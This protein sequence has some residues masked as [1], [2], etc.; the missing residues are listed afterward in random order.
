MA[1]D[2]IAAWDEI[3]SANLLKCGNN[4]AEAI[5]RSVKENRDAHSAYIAAY[6]A[7]HGSISDRRRQTA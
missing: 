5:R 1:K 4:R 7:K 6:N 2:P 3:V